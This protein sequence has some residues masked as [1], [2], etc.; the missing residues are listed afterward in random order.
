MKE[1]TAIIRRERIKSTKESLVEAGFPSLHICDV[2]GR[3]KQVGLKYSTTPKLKEEEAARAR[4]VGM[5][6]LPKKMLTMMVGDEDVNK[7]VD[8]I[9]KA[10]QTKEIGD[11][12]IF[13][14]PLNDAVRLRTGDR[15]GEAL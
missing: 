4:E 12:K 3:G 9:I 1:V 5:R 6:F 7:V 2:E 11:G 8:V 13:I 15:G 14:S 10:N